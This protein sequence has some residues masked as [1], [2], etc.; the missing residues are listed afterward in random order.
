MGRTGL[1]FTISTPQELFILRKFSKQTGLAIMEKVMSH[2]Q[3][4]DPEQ[5]REV[6]NER[7]PVHKKRRFETK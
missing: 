4:L 6:S 2:G 1:V 3:L 7:R 5:A